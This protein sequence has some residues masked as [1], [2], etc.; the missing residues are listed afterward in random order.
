MAL[1]MSVSRL[2]QIHNFGPDCNISTTMGWIDAE[3]ATHIHCSKKFNLNDVW[4]LLTSEL[5]P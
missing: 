2:I 4:D 5:A 1:G 3:L